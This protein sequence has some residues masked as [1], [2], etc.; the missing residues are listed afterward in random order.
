[1]GVVSGLAFSGDAAG[2]KSR[3]IIGIFMEESRVSGVPSSE[4]TDRRGLFDRRLRNV[5]SVAHC[6][7]NERVAELFA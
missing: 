1:M 7:A 6:I 2:I 4:R 5:M 3:V